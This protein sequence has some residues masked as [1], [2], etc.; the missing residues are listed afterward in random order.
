META[1]FNIQCCHVMHYHKLSATM[2]SLSGDAAEAAYRWPF[3]INV[4]KDVLNGIS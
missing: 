2:L 3:L 1:S 4:L